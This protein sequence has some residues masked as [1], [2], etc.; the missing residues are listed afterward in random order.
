MKEISSNETAIEVTEALNSSTRW[1]VFT[2]YTDIEVEDVFVLHN[3]E[4]IMTFD[5]WADGQPNNIGDNQ[6]CVM[7]YFSD[8]KLYDASCHTKLQPV[9][10]IVEVNFVI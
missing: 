6:D 7:M 8:L 3:T 9:C 1:E 10:N 4:K 2:G 5:N